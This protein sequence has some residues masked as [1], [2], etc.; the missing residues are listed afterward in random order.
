MRGEEMTGLS[1]TAQVVFSLPCVFILIQKLNLPMVV[2]T[3]ASNTLFMYV[4]CIFSKYEMTLYN[5][6]PK[7][8]N[9]E[10]H[11]QTPNQ[12]DGP[13]NDLQKYVK[14]T[15]ILHCNCPHG[16]TAKYTQNKE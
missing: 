6:H 11:K 8:I 2:Q 10:D 7:K 12:I 4:L 16:G 1:G 5:L 9:S 15:F 13:F 14:Q 3:E